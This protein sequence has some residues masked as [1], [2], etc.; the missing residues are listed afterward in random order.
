MA[1]RCRRLNTRSSVPSRV[2]RPVSSNSTRCTIPTQPACR[3]ARDADGF[4]AALDARPAGAVDDV[5]SAGGD[6]EGGGGTADGGQQFAGGGDEQCGGE[7][8]VALLRAGAGLGRHSRVRSRWWA[9]SG[10]A[11][12]VSTRGEQTAS[13]MR[14]YC[15]ATSGSSSP[16]IGTSPSSCGR[17]ER[18]GA[19]RE[20]LRPRGVRR[21]P[22]RAPSP[23]PAPAAEHV[24]ACRRRGIGTFAAGFGGEH[25]VGGEDQVAADPVAETGERSRDGEEPVEPHLTV[26]E[27]ITHRGEHR[28]AAAS[29]R[30][31]SGTATAFA[32][33]CNRPAD[34][35]LTLVQALDEFADIVTAHPGREPQIPLRGVGAAGH[36]TGRL[37]EDRFLEPAELTGEH[38]HIE[39]L[40]VG[41]TPDRSA[42]DPLGDAGTGASDHLAEGLEQCVHTTIL[43][44]ATDIP[45]RF[46]P[47]Q[48][49]NPTNSASGDRD[50]STTGCHPIAETTSPRT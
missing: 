32:A 8:V 26:E 28:L 41:R 16:R 38:H 5:V 45:S 23:T 13:M 4:V 25:G 22:G 30:I 33:R 15:A 20:L 40:A 36:L 1:R 42:P 24:G 21:R 29:P 2:T 34:P 37:D 19:R 10:R 14:W 31:D 46:S 18:R 35:G 17:S 3:A 43:P 12:S 7:G 48:K 11:A 44:R 50:A 39:N 49:K 27:R 6:D 47:V 9:G